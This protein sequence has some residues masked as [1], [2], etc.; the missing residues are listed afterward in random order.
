[1]IA[2]NNEAQQKDDR[3]EM[4]IDNED[5]KTYMS[6]TY[7][8]KALELDDGEDDTDSSEEMHPQPPPP[9]ILPPRASQCRV[10]GANK[11]TYNYRTFLHCNVNSLVQY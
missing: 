7:G 10:R 2:S 4:D 5:A 11:S 3:E 1:M 8:T 9:M 6:V